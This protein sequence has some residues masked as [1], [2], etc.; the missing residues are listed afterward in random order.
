[1]K[2][3]HH[4]TKGLISTPTEREEMAHN[5]LCSKMAESAK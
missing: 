2:Y 5:V 4:Q 3:S 1:M